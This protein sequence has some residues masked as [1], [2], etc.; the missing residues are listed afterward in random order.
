ME[1]TKP[2]A[3]QLVDFILGTTPIV[4]YFGLVLMILFELPRTPL[5]YATM[6]VAAMPGTYLVFGIHELGHHV[7]AE[8]YCG[9]REVYFS[10][11]KDTLLPT[12][13]TLSLATGLVLVE[14]FTSIQIPFW[15]YLLGL[16]SPGAVIMKGQSKR[17]SCSDEVALA[18][19]MLGGLPGL[20]LWWGT[21]IGIPTLAMDLPTFALSI[22]MFLS[23]GLTI[24]NALPLPGLDG[25]HVLSVGD[26]D[27][28]LPMVLYIGLCFAGIVTL[29]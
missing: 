5:N 9:I 16:V 20:L 22:A 21:D 8:D 18:G 23:L 17:A 3:T 27:T 1:S 6:S 2:R 19:I 4:A 10:T 28:V 14:T 15:I 24:F 26:P 13:L 7:V 11:L 29:V 12:L 25:N